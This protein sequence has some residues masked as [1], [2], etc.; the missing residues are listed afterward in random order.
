MKGEYVC[1]VCPTS[2][3]VHAEWNEKELLNIDR[4]QCKLAWAYVEGEIF[5]PRRMVSTTVSVRG[6]DLPMVSIKTD[7]PLP[8]DKMMEL[9]SLVNHL[10]TSAP[11]RIGD[12]IAADVLDTGINLVAT[13]NV[14]ERA[15]G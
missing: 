6:G 3:T 2:C 7:K 14:V 10:E 1:V 4:A 13:R 9:M 11:I 5:D 15:A 12:V 8:K